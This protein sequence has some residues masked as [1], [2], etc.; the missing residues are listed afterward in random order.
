MQGRILAISFCLLCVFSLNSGCGTAVKNPMDSM[1][2]SMS[3]FQSSKAAE[4]KEEETQRQKYQTDRDPD[5]M[6]WLLR[7]RIH[8]GM[9][10]AD[11]NQ[12]LGEDGERERDAGWVKNTGG[13]YRHDDDVF[14]WGP[15]ANGRTIYLVF[16]D[17]CLTNYDPLQFD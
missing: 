6:R 15:D 5:A 3:L 1:R 4:K 8:Q 12:I 2:K 17:D 14:K 13:V 7:H 10:L 16:R 9:A 11:V